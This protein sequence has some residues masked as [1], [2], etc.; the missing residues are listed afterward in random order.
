MEPIRPNQRF[1]GFRR[2][3]FGGESGSARDVHSSQT[4]FFQRLEQVEPDPRSLEAERVE[5][6]ELVDAPTERLLDEVHERGQRLL[7]ERTYSAAQAYRAAVQAFLRKVLSD[8]QSFETVESS[9]DILSRKRY[10]LLGAVNR[11]VDRLIQGVLQTQTSQMEI[12]TRLEEIRGLLVD[13]MQ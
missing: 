8:G 4:P 10:M 11:A 1:Q 12:L 6:H 13:I 5:Q 3:S 2:K 9:H 7:K